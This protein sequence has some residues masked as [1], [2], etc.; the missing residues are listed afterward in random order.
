MSTVC[1]SLR[2]NEASLVRGL[3]CV[4]PRVGLSA[5][6]GSDR[7]DISPMRPERVSRFSGLRFRPPQPSFVTSLSS[8][9]LAP[10][11]VKVT[12]R[13]L[14]RLQHPARQVIPSAADVTPVGVAPVG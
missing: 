6:T 12:H 10:D 11:S 3:F 7:R 5:P 1:D 2:I 14:H 9:S 8:M 4:Q 13:T